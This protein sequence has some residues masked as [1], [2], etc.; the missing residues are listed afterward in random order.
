MRFASVPYRP[1][2]KKCNEA[3]KTNKAVQS[4]LCT[5]TGLK[6]VIVIGQIVGAMIIAQKLPKSHHFQDGSQK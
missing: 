6:R 4:G 5:V 3:V 1:G 2:Q